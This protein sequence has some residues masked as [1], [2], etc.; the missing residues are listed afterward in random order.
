MNNNLETRVRNIAANME[1]NFVEIDGYEVPHSKFVEWDQTWDVADDLE[2]SEDSTDEEIE[3]AILSQEFTH[4]DYYSDEV[5]EYVKELRDAKF[6][7]DPDAFDEQT[8]DALVDAFKEG[9]DYGRKTDK[10][11]PSD[12]EIRAAARKVLEQES[13]DRK[14][15][16]DALFIDQEIDFHNFGYASNNWSRPSADKCPVSPEWFEQCG[17]D[18]FMEE[19]DLTVED[20]LRECMKNAYVSWFIDNTISR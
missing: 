8:V 15:R 12:S 19:D 9:M 6:S 3:K 11:I 2:I 18:F 4:D 5:N 20:A 17:G 7:K 1:G 13:K 10:A 14:V 16:Q